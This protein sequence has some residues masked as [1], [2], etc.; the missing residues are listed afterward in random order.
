[1]AVSQAA[2]VVAAQPVR[3][4]LTELLESENLHNGQD[5]LILA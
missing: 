4:E 5:F 2:L 1:M 3:E